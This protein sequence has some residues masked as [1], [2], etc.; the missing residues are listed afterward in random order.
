MAR[1]S[2]CC[3]TTT[4]VLL[5][6]AFLPL[7]CGAQTFPAPAP[8]LAYGFYNTSCPSAESTVQQMMQSILTSN[9][10]EAAGIIRLFFHDCFV[11]GCDG[12]LL[13]NATNGE[14]F[15][16]PN[17]TIRRSAIAIVEQIKAR[18]ESACPNTVS[19]SDILVLAARE[20][21]T[22]A[23]GPSFPVPTGRRDGTTFA[24][25]Q[26]VL[27]FIPAPSFNFSQLNSSFQTK[28]LNE[29]DLTALSGAHTIGIAHCSAFIGNL[30]PNV[31]SR[32]NS[33]FAQTLL[34][35]C[36]SNTSNNVVNMDLVTPNAFDS[37]YFSNVLSGS[38]DF[39]SDAALLNSTTTQSSV[40]AFAANQTQFFNQF[41]VS[42]IKM[43][44]IEVLTNSSGNIRNVCSVFNSNSSSTI[45][46]N[47]S[48]ENLVEQ[49]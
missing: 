46:L 38:V 27:S 36:P 40:Q 21:V 30:Y 23:G 7:L 10:S 19:C 15:S 16:I 24:S 12:S 44:M 34:Q 17:L 48:P 5:V 3:S 47:S 41:A 31:S 28:G 43:S 9:I 11:Q 13:I 25:N 18:L 33:S 14:L 20:S 39:D 22:Q 29:A 1:G 8:G 2:F 45:S 42:F 49:V 6:A 37:Q 4:V 32:F 35:S 26:T